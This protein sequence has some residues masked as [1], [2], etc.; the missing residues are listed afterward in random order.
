MRSWLYS[1]FKRELQNIAKDLSH[2]S[3]RFRRRKIEHLRMLHKSCNGLRRAETGPVSHS[4]QTLRPASINTR[5]PRVE[6]MASLQVMKGR[7]F[8]P[9]KSKTSTG[10]LYAHYTVARKRRFRNSFHRNQRI[11][12]NLYVC[13][14][15]IQPH[16]LMPELV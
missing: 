8:S 1:V 9:C 11:Y 6:D 10:R 3:V 4:K 16:N 7:D 13:M 5:R 15:L 2:R 12:I 14:N